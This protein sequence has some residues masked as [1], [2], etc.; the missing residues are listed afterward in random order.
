MPALRNLRHERFARAFIKTNV[1]ARAYAKAGYIATTRSSLDTCAS[2]LLRHAQVKRRIAELRKQMAAR[3]RIS[4][5]SLLDDLAADRALARTLGQPSA[6]I[7]ATQ[8][9]AR[10]CGLLVDRKESG[11]P[12]EFAGL[13]SEAEVLA[14]V[15]RELGDDSATALAAALAQ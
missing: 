10:L 1:A 15:R 5:D 4:L 12:G 9:T 8:L 14:L 2:R 6:A 3:N 13:Q 11:Q 7:A